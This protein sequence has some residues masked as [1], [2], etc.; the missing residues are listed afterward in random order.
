[1]KKIMM[2]L[3]MA[4]MISALVACGSDSSVEED[5]SA[6]VDSEEEAIG[7]DESN[8]DESNEEDS[9]EDEEVIEEGDQTVE[10]EK[11][12]LSVEI[13]IPASFFEGQELDEIIEDA[14]ADGIEEVQKNDDG[15]LTYKMS[16]STHKEFLAELETSLQESM[17]ELKT[18]ED[19]VS[20]VDITANRS[21]SEFSL[22]VD[23]EAFE[24][25]FDGF[26][27][28]GLAIGGMYYQL[29]DGVNPEQYEV[30]IELED[31]ESG[32]VFDTVT[33]PDALEEEN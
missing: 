23:Q 25:S 31:A 32:E 17:E 19:F 18:S 9:I 6:D 12:L 3:F 33:F 29:F 13:T 4:L 30:T 5:E 22:V 11:G 15:S 10:V 1:M 8:E 24:N 28:L 2:L 20:I 16:K 21:F 7:E 14:K 26:A 27:I